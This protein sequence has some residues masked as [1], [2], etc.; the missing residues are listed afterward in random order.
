MFTDLRNSVL[1]II[2]ES[3]KTAGTAFF[4]FPR[5]YIITCTHVLDAIGP[6]DYITLD[7]APSG[8]EHFR[9]LRAV[10]CPEWTTSTN[11]EDISILKTLDPM[12]GDARPLYLSSA[13][14]QI[15]APVD[16]FGFS[17][18]NPEH[19]MPGSAA[20]IGL[21]RDAKSGF[22][23][24]VLNGEMVARGFSGGPCV[25]RE[26]GEVI[27]VVGAITTP[28]REG[29]WGRGSFVI[30]AATVLRIC[31]E[32]ASGVPEFVSQ[33]SRAWT[34]RPEP[35]Q[36]YNQFDQ[37]DERI[38]DESLPSLERV[39]DVG[40]TLESIADVL[41]SA[42]N[43]SSTHIVTIIGAPGTGK[44]R[45][46][47]TLAAKT[48]E[49]PDDL[50]LSDRFVPLLLTAKSFVQAAGTSL[51]E[52]LAGGLRADGVITSRKTV[53]ASDIQS[54]LDD[55]RFRCAVLLD[56][57]D[58]I[59]SPI[60]RQACIRLLASVGPQLLDAGHLVVVTSRPLDNFKNIN[61][62]KIS[63]Q[64][65]LPTLSE[66]QADE[67]IVRSLGERTFDFREII[68]SSGLDKY[69]DT[70]L[71]LN[72]ATT[73]YLSN[74]SAF[75]TD[76]I[77][78]YSSVVAEISKNWQKPPVSTE[79]ITEVLSNLALVSLL[80]NFETDSLT[81][82]LREV[83]FLTET[84]FLE[85]LKK[86][87]DVKQALRTAQAVAH[88]VL[89][90][91]GIISQTGTAINWSHLL[92]RDYLVTIALRAR[93]EADP[94]SVVSILRQQYANPTWREAL[95]LFIVQ[96]SRDGDA[97]ALLHE[98]ETVERRFSPQLIIFI[99]DCIFRG[100]VLRAEFL[101]HY[102]DV[103]ASYAEDDQDSFGACSRV[104]AGD[105]G[106][107]WHLLMLQGIPE[108]QAS[109][110]NCVRRAKPTSIV[111]EWPNSERARMFTPT[112]LYRGALSTVEPMY[113][114]SSA[115]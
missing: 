46:L 93:S 40:M 81:P 65:Q 29:R 35:F 67:L 108:A 107:F 52:R 14:P 7:F 100:C 18:H 83:D 54:L 90:S 22:E 10:L 9:R 24:F 41:A 71:L 113:V 85:F 42:T 34:F 19:G 104:L 70:P 74:K 28:D 45:L 38:K 1:R 57:V 21:T 13:Y 32:I 72:L 98:I 76:I 103:F 6:H 23:T 91:T 12:P 50:N 88:Y 61:L 96:K 36:K 49:R 55:G 115:A 3:G 51:A 80:P 44:S 97:D 78:L 48:W 53:E 20:F 77:E 99:K 64:Y 25:S 84:I 114:R 111:S 73:L 43:A 56:G 4:C 109:I 11:D 5:G 8:N 101:A 82:W 27:G 30:H 110:L 15:E 68:S 66:K 86:F 47:S 63:I 58:E 26:S 112:M 87:H 95:I 2:S 89:E 39:T 79:V 37:I 33:L 102:F 62:T 17:A 59:E 75:P 94:D 31:P 60:D 69:L 16:T 105:Y 106:I 92:I